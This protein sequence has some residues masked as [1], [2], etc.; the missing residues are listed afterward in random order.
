MKGIYR[1]EI[2]LPGSPLKAVNSYVIKGR[3]RNLIIDT[4][5]RRKECLDAMRAGLDALDISLP[6]TDFF[7]THFHADHL[8]LVSDLATE[9]A[10]YLPERAGR[11]PCSCRRV[12][13][14]PQK[15]RPPARLSRSRA[16]RMP[17]T[18]IRRACTAPNSPS[19]LHRPMT[20][21]PYARAAIT[22]GALRRPATV[23]A[24]PVSTTPKTAC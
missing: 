10:V 21:K 7:I 19:A 6:D 24:I 12:L 20:V 1:L 2:P 17:S 13:R 5:M 16:A 15:L 23:S 11:S 4:G 9:T 18:V 8:G 14:H 3:E 22:S